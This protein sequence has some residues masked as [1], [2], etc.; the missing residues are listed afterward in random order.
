VNRNGKRGEEVTP[1]ATTNYQPELGPEEST[2][3]CWQREALQ[4]GSGTGSGGWGPAGSEAPEG[5]SKPEVVPEV[6]VRTTPEVRP[7]KGA[8]S[9]SGTGS[10]G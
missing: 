10:G 8:Q 1:A 5:R 3:H 4:T 7:R 2:L 6:E 9:G